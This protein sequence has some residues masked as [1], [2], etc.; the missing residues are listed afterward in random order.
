MYM[1]TKET[2]THSHALDNITHSYT[3]YIP[4]RYTHSLET[5]TYTEHNTGISTH[6]LLHIC[7]KERKYADT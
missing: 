4:Q 2:F 3:M 5:V 1:H 6:T 7:Y